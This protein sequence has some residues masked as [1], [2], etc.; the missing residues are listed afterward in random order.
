MRPGE[1]DVN[2]TLV[3]VHHF[4]SARVRYESDPGPDASFQ[5]CQ[6]HLKGAGSYAVT[7]VHLV[8]QKLL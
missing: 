8:Y 1:A 7:S 4:S 3:L 2:L 6:G 5:F